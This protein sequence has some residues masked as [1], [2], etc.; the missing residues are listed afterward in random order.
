MTTTCANCRAE[1]GDAA[2]CPEC[3]QAVLSPQSS[4]SS[5]GRPD[6][7]TD[8]F[9]R[10]AERVPVEPPP[11]VITPGPPRFPLYADGTE[12]GVE[13]HVD[14]QAHRPAEPAYPTYLPEEPDPDDEE[15]TEVWRE[16][17]PRVDTLATLLDQQ[18][19]DLE[20]P[21]EWTFAGDR[22]QLR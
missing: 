5:G 3:G 19:Y 18:R 1:V 16:S 6:W 8:T 9:E 15:T 2:Y 22:F 17:L 7:R 20:T 21:L 13:P 14:P 12:D 4:P 11:A 10:P